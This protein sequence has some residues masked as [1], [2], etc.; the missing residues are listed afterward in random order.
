VPCLRRLVA[1]LSPRKPGLDPGLVHVRFVVDKVTL[2]H[3]FL[4]LLRFSPVSIIPPLLRTLFIY[5]LLLSEGQTGEAWERSEKQSYSEIGEHWIEKKFHF[6]VF[7]VGYWHC[8]WRPVPALATRR[9][10]QGPTLPLLGPSHC[11][12]RS[13]SPS[14]FGAP[15]QFSSD[16]AMY[17]RRDSTANNSLTNSIWHAIFRCNCNLPLYWISYS[18]I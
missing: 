9:R 11:P 7:T 8:Y 10:P 2:G 4:R 6:L 14:E 5:T 3:V 16:V 13:M 15:E 1:G 18:R 17:P 12:T